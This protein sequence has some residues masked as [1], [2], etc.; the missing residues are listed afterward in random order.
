MADVSAGGPPRRGDLVQW[1]LHLD[2][3]YQW[4][5][6]WVRRLT[7]TRPPDGLQGPDCEWKRFAGLVTFDG[8]KL[9]PAPHQWPTQSGAMFGIDWDR[10]GRT[11][12]LTTVVAVGSAAMWGGKFWCQPSS[13]GDSWEVIAAGR[14]VATAPTA[15][16]AFV[17]AA[18]AHRGPGVAGAAR[19]AWAAAAP[20]NEDVP[21]VWLEPDRPATFEIW[22]DGWTRPWPRAVAP[23]AELA[24]AGRPAEDR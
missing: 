17:L 6:G 22:P 15:E 20:A 11:T 24:A 16:A 4:S 12:V 9:M 3:I 5:G 1:S 23:D 21:P 13:D 2:A 18:L 14:T 10:D 7:G 19:G 8:R